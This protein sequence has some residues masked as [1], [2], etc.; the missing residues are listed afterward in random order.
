MLPSCI[1]TEVW[2]ELAE[3]LSVKL[4]APVV[5]GQAVFGKLSFFQE[6]RNRSSDSPHSTVPGIR[7]VSID[8]DGAPVHV[9]PFRTDEPHAFDEELSDARQKLPVWK[10]EYADLIETA[11]KQAAVAG[12][13]ER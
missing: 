13:S 2:R 6:L 3:S 10:P 11:V 4:K 12:R 8:I 7:Y 1:K 9:G 5:C